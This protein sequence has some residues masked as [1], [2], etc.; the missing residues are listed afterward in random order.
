MVLL[1]FNKIKINN[2]IVSPA[3]TLWTT[4]FD[5]SYINLNIYI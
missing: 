2:Y 5:S 3:N 4:S 1:I